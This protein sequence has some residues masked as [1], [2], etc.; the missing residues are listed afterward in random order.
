VI[1][2]KVDIKSMAVF[3][4]EN[5]APRA[6]HLHGIKSLQIAG[7][8]VKLA[9]VSGGLERHSVLPFAVGM[10]SVYLP[11]FLAFGYLVSW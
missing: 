6:K 8:Y 1:V 11:K 3:E 5:N 7:Q 9:A 2:D 10:L 4:P